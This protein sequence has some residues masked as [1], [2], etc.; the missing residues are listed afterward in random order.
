[1]RLRGSVLRAMGLDRHSASRGLR[2]LAAISHSG[3][4]SRS[5]PTRGR[6]LKRGFATRCPE[7]SNRPPRV[8]VGATFADREITAPWRFETSPCHGGKTISEPTDGGKSEGSGASDARSARRRP[9]YRILDLRRSCAV[10]RGF[11]RG[12]H[13]ESRGRQKSFGTQCP[14][15][16]QGRF[17]EDT[18]KSTPNRPVRDSADVPLALRRAA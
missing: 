13:G 4:L 14:E 15:T 10:K 11:C 12:R 5:P 9:K 7:T 8:G 2:Q 6:G 16:L 18:P 1:V 3:V 17:P